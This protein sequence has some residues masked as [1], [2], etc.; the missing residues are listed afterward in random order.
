MPWCTLDVF[1]AEEPPIH[2]PHD[3]LFKETFSHLEAARDFFQTH[4]PAPLVAGL[5]W[6][7]LQ[8]V[9]GSFVAEQLAEQ[10]S[11]LLYRVAWQQW[12]LYLYCLFEHQSTV[13]PDMPFRLLS[14]MVRIWEQHR[15]QN[16]RKA[17]PP[18]ILPVVLYQGPGPWTVSQQFLDWLIMPEELRVEL[19]PY[20]PDFVHLLVDLAE[21]SMEQ[22]GRD[23]LGRLT[24]SL[25]K[26]VA[27]GRGMEWM[28]RTVP[29][30]AEFLTQKD[31]AGQFRTLLRYLLRAD[32]NAPSTFVDLVAKIENE[33]VKEN[34]M[35]IA[36]QLIQQGLEKGLEKGLAEGLQ[37]G[38]A[39]GS[40]IGRIQAYQEL[41][42]LPVTQ[43]AELEQRNP[44]E[45]ETLWREL[46]TEV[47]RR[48]A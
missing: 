17:K 46:Q 42:N 47:R 36:D 7:T 34:V 19:A 23:L 41:L 21:L 26:A 31:R 25:M 13:D 11:D 8:L 22:M 28:V 24:L 33:T 35:S 6:E 38:L 40:L 30:L 37:K 27:E 43:L 32:A 15:R 18:P 45:L 5:D 1:M 44:S 10:S 4:L 16:A 12:P 3:R 39:R 20:Q 14:Y 48:L 2:S 9:P 29:F